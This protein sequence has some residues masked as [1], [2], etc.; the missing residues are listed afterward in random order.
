M[1]RIIVATV[2]VALVISGLMAG[3]DEL[4]K[5]L[6]TG[7]GNLETVAF[8][9]SDFSELEVGYSYKVDI[10]SSDS[11]SISITVDDNLL[12]HLDVRKSG[13]TLIITMDS[14]YNYRDTTQLATVTMP[15]I[16]EL[17]LSGA[18]AADIGAFRTSDPVYF[19]LSGASSAAFE[20]LLAGDAS[21]H[22]SGA[23][24]ASGSVQVYDC[25][26]EVSGA[27]TI[28]F[29]G[30]GNDLSADVSGASRLSLEGF[31]FNN[32]RVDLSGASTGT[33]N[34]TGTLDASASGASHLRYIG[35]PTLG[36]I[37]TS[38]A[39]TVRKL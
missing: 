32:A 36:D 27:S 20:N 10:S 31:K 29:V 34:L 8:E 19:R 7:S 21:F 38:S 18:S 16:S 25:E 12:D 23:S 35:D 5:Q 1:N 17:I 24:H 9:Y 6:I 33:V 15:N 28:A 11:Y 26:M 30:S 13:D 22:L 39:S 14:G 37:D 3:C 4:D 2:I